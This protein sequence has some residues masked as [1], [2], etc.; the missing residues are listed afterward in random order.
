MINLMLRLTCRQCSLILET[1]KK[2]EGVWGK[3][4]AIPLVLNLGT[5]WSQKIVG[6]NWI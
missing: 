4:G 6:K 1:K 5:R 2:Q 3:T